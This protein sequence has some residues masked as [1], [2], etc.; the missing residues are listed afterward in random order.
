LQF[1]FQNFLKI[2][3]KDT[4]LFSFFLF[5]C[6]SLYCQTLDRFLQSNERKIERQNDR[7]TFRGLKSIPV[8][9]V[10]VSCL[11]NDSNRDKEGKTKQSLA[12]EIVLAVVVVGW[13][14]QKY[15]IHNH[16]VTI[17]YVYLGTI[18]SIVRLNS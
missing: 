4:K 18:F 9:F 15:V 2:F 16:H 8:R 7:K 6:L 11:R 12:Q 5:L 13:A 14:E 1:Q 10:Q 3:S 17:I